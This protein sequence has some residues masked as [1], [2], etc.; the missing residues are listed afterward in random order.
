MSGKLEISSSSGPKARPSWI[1]PVLVILGLTSSLLVI[2]SSEGWGPAY[3][4]QSGKALFWTSA[5][6]I[7]VIAVNAKEISTQSG[8]RWLVFLLVSHL[9]LVMATYKDLG[10]LSF[11]TLTPVCFL[12]IALCS[13]A[14]AHVNKRMN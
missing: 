7:P 2:A 1:N 4:D 3:L 13:I 12:E 6:V 8:K 10:R 14:F 5:V 11:L 9:I